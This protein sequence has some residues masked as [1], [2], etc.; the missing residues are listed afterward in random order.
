MQHITGIQRNQM[1]LSSLEDTIT[2]DNPVR[3]IDAFVG[4][5]D[6]EKLG[7][8]IRVLKTE[9][10]PSFETAVFLKVYLLSLIHI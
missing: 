10:R 3:F 7:F 6:L 2:A 1:M 4:T 9:G 8:S 5:I